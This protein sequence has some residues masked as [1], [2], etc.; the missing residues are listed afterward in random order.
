MKLDAFQGRP[1]W[2]DVHNEEIVSALSAT[3]KE[4]CKR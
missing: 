1:L 4:L 3:E 2:Q